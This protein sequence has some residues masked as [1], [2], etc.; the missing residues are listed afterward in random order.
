MKFQLLKFSLTFSSF[1]ETSRNKLRYLLA[2]SSLAIKGSFRRCDTIPLLFLFSTFPLWVSLHFARTATA[3]PSLSSTVVSSLSLFPNV[4]PTSFCIRASSSSSFLNPLT[5]PPFFP[6]LLS[7]RVHVHPYSLWLLHFPM[8]EAEQE[9]NDWLCSSHLLL[10][11]RAVK[12]KLCSARPFIT[13]GGMYA[14]VSSTRRRTLLWLKFFWGDTWK[15]EPV[16][17]LNSYG[18]FSP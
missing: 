12:G 13:S 14:P 9:S 15:C 10:A 11:L 17:C 1:S 7:S 6:S 8:T 5:L 18:T 3:P 4:S 16:E 2:D